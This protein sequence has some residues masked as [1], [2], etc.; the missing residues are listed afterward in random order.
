MRLHRAFGAVWRASDLV[1]RL[2][3]S[4]VGTANVERAIAAILPRLTD[5]ETAETVL[6]AALRPASRSESLRE[7]SGLDLAAIVRGIEVPIVLTNG[8]RDWPTRAGEAM[9]L[10][11]NRRAKLVLAHRTGHGMGLLAPGVMLRAIQR[12]FAETARATGARAL[13]RLES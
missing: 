9:V 3:E 8:I 10:R 1:S 6:D 12:V 4:A 5:R 13:P 7:L 2:L 11:A